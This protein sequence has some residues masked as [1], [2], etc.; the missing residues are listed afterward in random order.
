MKRL[1]GSTCAVLACVL[2]PASSFAGVSNM[3]LRSFSSGK[4]AIDAPLC[5]TLTGCTLPD[6]MD[7]TQNQPAISFDLDMDRTVHIEGDVY[8]APDCQGDFQ[9]AMGDL[10]LPGGHDIVYLN[11]Q[12]PLPA[13]TQLAIDWRAGSAPVCDTGCVNYTIGTDPALC[14]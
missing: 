10:A 6:P 2:L 5:D 14:Q 13:G 3:E 12:P 1:I 4:S 8:A 9:T 11:F 7:P